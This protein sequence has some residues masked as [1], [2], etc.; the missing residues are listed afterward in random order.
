[1]V[2]CMKLQ[3]NHTEMK[4]ARIWEQCEGIRSFELDGEVDAKA[5]QFVMALMP[6]VSENPF[7]VAYDKPLR[8][9][10]KAVGDEKSFTNRL[11]R[12]HKGDALQMTGPL[13]NGYADLLGKGE[14]I[15]I[16][17]GGCGAAGF[18]LLEK[19]L[20]VKGV[21]RHYIIGA[22]SVDSIPDDAFKIEGDVTFATEDGSFG[23]GGTVIDGLPLHDIMIEHNRNDAQA[24]VCGPRKMLIEAGREL[25][26]VMWPDHIIVSLEPYMKCGRGVCGSCEVAGYHVCTDGPNFRY[27][28]V[29]D[30]PDFMQYKRGKSGALEPI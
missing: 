16:I 26:G 14:P 9:M 19:D 24:I 4:I 11:F 12:M 13:G 18:P 10:V 1:M 20:G 27:S 7:T 6:G 23:V 25:C 8:L 3:H 28:D 15:Y 5:G 22:R 2:T 29:M 30:A 21:R 17:M